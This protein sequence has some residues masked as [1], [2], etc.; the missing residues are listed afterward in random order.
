MF[1]YPRI[2]TI[3]IVGTDIAH[4]VPLTAVA[5][6]GHMQLGTVDT[7]LLVALLLGSLPGI[8]IGSHFG[9]VVPER[10]MRPLLASIL[11]VI[12]VKFSLAH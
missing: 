10:I 12:G 4:A 2:P 6:L 11:V 7:S 5:G 8:Y 1:L 3:R 9:T